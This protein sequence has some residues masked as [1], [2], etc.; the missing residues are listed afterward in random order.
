MRRAMRVGV[1]V[2]GFDTF[3]ASRG[4]RRQDSDRPGTP[5]DIG[6]FLGDRA[7]GGPRSS[8]LRFFPDLR[9]VADH[10]LRRLVGD[11]LV[12]IDWR[13]ALCASIEETAEWHER[14]KCG[15]RGGVK[16]GQYDSGIA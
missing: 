7:I 10:V 3:A 6:R 13:V 14:K 11:G 12:L 16:P 9:V 15:R 1:A 2:Q 5:I 4:S 8:V